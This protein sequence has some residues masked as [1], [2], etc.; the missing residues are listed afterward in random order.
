MHT[1]KTLENRVR[2]EAKRKGYLLRRSRSRDPHTDDYGLYVLVGDS[3]GNRLPSAQASRS[4]FANGEGD[5]L[6]G[7]AEVL[8]RLPE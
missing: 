3:R 6:A 8:A 1:D 4:A 2:R 7:V 5:T